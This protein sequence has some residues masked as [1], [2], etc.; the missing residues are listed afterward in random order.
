MDAGGP[1]AEPSAARVLVTDDDA[2]TRALLRDYLEA[3]GFQV[4]EAVNGA[5]AVELVGRMGS[6]MSVV[7]LDIAMPQCDGLAAIR[8]IKKL[9]PKLPV[10]VV[11]GSAEEREIREAYARGAIRV[12]KKPIALGDLGLVIERVTGHWP[13]AG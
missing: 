11:T 6:E 7:V 12:L 8:L 9:V 4:L 13:R 10:V 5:Q 3:D 2:E 1:S